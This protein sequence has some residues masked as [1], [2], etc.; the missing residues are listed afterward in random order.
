MIMNV[1]DLL[2][3]NANKVLMNLKHTMLCMRCII[4]ILQDIIPVSRCVAIS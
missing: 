2:F 3:A 1:E 4:I